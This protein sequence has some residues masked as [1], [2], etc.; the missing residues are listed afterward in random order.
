MVLRGIGIR[1]VL[2]AGLSPV[3]GLFHHGR[4]NAF[5]LVDDLIEPFRPAIDWSVAQLDADMSPAH[6]SVKA[7]LV[8]A[9]N[10]PFSSDGST[11]PTTL[12][13]LAQR[14]G[15]YFEGDIDQLAVPSWSGPASTEKS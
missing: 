8:A 7:A 12:L 15:R 14:L 13:D 6:P 11:V 5:N 2:G 9:A 4:S 1:A 3:L 10:Q